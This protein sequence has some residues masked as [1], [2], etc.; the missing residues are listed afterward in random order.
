MLAMIWAL[1]TANSAIS[2]RPV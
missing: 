2:I 1:D